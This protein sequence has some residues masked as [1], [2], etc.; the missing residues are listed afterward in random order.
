MIGTSPYESWTQ[1][2]ARAVLALF[3]VLF[4]VFLV[5]P[6]LAFVPMAF[7][8]VALLHYPIQH[9]SLR[10]FRGLIASPEWSRALLNSL[11]VAVGTPLLATALGVSA[12]LGLWRGRFAGRNLIMAIVMTP[13]IVPS[14]IGA[15][16]MYFAFV[17]VGL[18]YSY[19]GLILAH[20]ALAVP[21]VVV[22]VSAVLE[23]FDGNFL[24]AAASLGAPPL[25]AFRRVTLPLILP[26][27]LSGAVFA[28]AISFDDVVVALFIAGPDQRTLPVQM[29]M[30][31]SD[32]FDLVIAAAAAIMLVVAFLLMIFLLFLK[33]RE[34]ITG[35]QAKPIAGDGQ[36]GAAL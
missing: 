3:G 7:N 5:G 10:W 20:A 35:G 27:V 24:R 15:A 21:L 12:A 23:R 4:C 6:I 31:S 22:T 13:M 16:S 17:R 2:W 19:V 32:L 36:G 28:F 11:L 30:R 18:D 14:V 34:R 29:Y 33:R 25:L 26:G 8:D 1:R 9:V